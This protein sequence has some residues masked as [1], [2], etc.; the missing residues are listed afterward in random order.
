MSLA[1]AAQANNLN[2][3]NTVTEIKYGSRNRRTHDHSMIAVSGETSVHD[4][5][6][7]FGTIQ[8][9]ARGGMYSIS[10]VVATCKPRNSTKI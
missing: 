6:R 5:A 2:Q 10:N 3:L 9:I 7:S 4:P 8:P 1:A